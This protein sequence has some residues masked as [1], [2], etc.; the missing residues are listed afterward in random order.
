VLEQPTIVT[1]TFADVMA[2]VEQDATLS[3][4]RR[5]DLLSS[6]RRFTALLELDPVR[7]RAGLV[8]YRDK[9]RRFA[10][11]AAD[12][13]PKA[14]SNILAG[15]RAAL[16]VAGIADEVLRPQPTPAW[17]MLASALVGGGQWR[18]LTRLIRYCS[19]YWIEPE[20]VDDATVE[21]FR[22]YLHNATTAAKPD[23]LTRMAC[24]AWN[25]AVDEIAG[26][27]QRHLTVPNFRRIVGLPWTDFPASL[28]REHS[29]W[30]GVLSGQ[31]PFDTR[32]PIKP[33]RPATLHA[34]SE[35]VR[36]FASAVVRSGTPIEVL[37][38]FAVLLEPQH[39]NSGLTWFL[40]RDGKSTPSTFEMTATLVH[41]AQHWLQLDQSALE[42]LRRA[43]DRLRCRQKGMTSKNWERL[44]ALCEPARVDRLLALPGKLARLAKRMNSP[45]QAALAVQT[46]VAIEILLTAPIRLGNLARLD[47]RRHV[48]LGQR[49]RARHVRLCIDG[50]EVKNGMRLDYELQGESA[51][52]LRDYI[53]QCLPALSDGSPGSLFPG[54][55]GGPKHVV[56]ISGQIT[57][58]M[59]DHLGLA[60]NPHL[61]R[62]FAAKL[63]LDEH[64]GEFA[65]VSR[66]LGHRSV[67][68]TLDFYAAFDNEAAARRYHDTV[69]L[70]RRGR[71]Q[72]G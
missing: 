52:L 4:A 22:T 66:L 53:N 1:A 47:L 32:A 51:K 41:I 63:Y 24:L 65:V 18:G 19:S 62:H 48:T 60:V 38:S 72:G 25:R 43:R 10:P 50:A 34:K 33:L 11:A 64:P 9:V 2:A 28:Q 67:Q 5:R 37:T 6:V 61:F 57:K 69:L 45:R 40:R 27:P 42:L 70:K 17:Q 20:S 71:R 31:H 35:Q 56:T 7:E 54:A 3:P 15:T 21:A 8:A 68:T 29:E 59:H 55:K 26:W 46:A 39:V 23:K 16:R 44:H 13:S 30:L 49:G 36:R 58:A 12:L 14:W